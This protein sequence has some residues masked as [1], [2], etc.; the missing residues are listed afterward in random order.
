MDMTHIENYDKMKV[1]EMAIENMRKY[2]RGGAGFINKEVVINY[3]IDQGHRG[4]AFG[5]AIERL[6]KETCFTD[7]ADSRA[8]DILRW[9][10]KIFGNAEIF[11]NSDCPTRAKTGFKQIGYWCTYA[12]ILSRS[13]KDIRKLRNMGNKTFEDFKDWFEYQGYELFTELELD[14][15]RSINFNFYGESRSL[16]TLKELLHMPQIT[17]KIAKNHMLWNPVIKMWEGNMFDRLKPE[18]QVV[19][20]MESQIEQHNAS[21]D[22]Q[23]KVNLPRRAT[24]INMEPE[25]GTKYFTIGKG[26]EIRQEI[27]NERVTS[28]SERLIRERI[29]HYAVEMTKQTPKVKKIKLD[30]KKYITNND[31]FNIIKTNPNSIYDIDPNYIRISGDIIYDYIMKSDLDVRTKFDLIEYVKRVND[32]KEELKF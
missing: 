13:E 26:E 10:A 30:E 29:T 17:R 9:M 6:Y 7:K 23:T 1:L 5:E 27:N 28:H 8:L 20:T 15:L 4:L 25:K 3:L 14:V 31:L 12:D 2:M 11:M 24:L 18:E 19:E 22:K 32:F 16:E 21:S